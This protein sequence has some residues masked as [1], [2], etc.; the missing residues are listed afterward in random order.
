MEPALSLAE[1]YDLTSNGNSFKAVF[2]IEENHWNGITSLQLNLKDIKEIEF[3]PINYW[4]SPNCWLTCATLKGIVKPIDIIESLEK[5]NIESRHIWKPMHMQPL[6]RD[7]LVVEDGT[8]RR[9]FEQGICLPSGSS[10]SDE[11]LYRVCDVIGKV[12]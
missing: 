2:T 4:N 5:E 3:M 6:F 10:M 12:L 9:L 7:A 11:D 1:K 8:S